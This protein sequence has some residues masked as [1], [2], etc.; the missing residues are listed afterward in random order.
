MSWTT[1]EALSPELVWASL[2]CAFLMMACTTC[3]RVDDHFESPASRGYPCLVI[4]RPSLLIRACGLGFHGCVLDAT[5]Q[6]PALGIHPSLL[7]TLMVWV[8]SFSV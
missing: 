2:P 7:G 5:P 8:C 3:S 1:L 6:S 4:V